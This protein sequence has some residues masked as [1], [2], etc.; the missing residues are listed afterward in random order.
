[1]RAGTMT[2]SDWIIVAT[3]IIMIL[4]SWFIAF[5]ML[6]AAHPGKIKALAFMKGF[7][8]TRWKYLS[9][10]FIVLLIFSLAWELTNSA[11]LTRWTVFFISLLLTSI[12]V[13]V[14][15]I[16][17]H[18]VRERLQKQINGSDNWLTAQIFNRRF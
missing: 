15:F 7:L 1:V 6:P 13:Q 12:F 10:I 11:P 8:T 18:I 2:I 17:I 4:N 3:T 14:V 5:V 9:S 16:Y